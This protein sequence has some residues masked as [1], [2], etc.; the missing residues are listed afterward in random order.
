MFLPKRFQNVAFSISTKIVFIQPFKGVHNY[1]NMYTKND[2]FRVQSV[3]LA[4]PLALPVIA[5]MLIAQL[6]IKTIFR[7]PKGI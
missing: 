5:L 3:E 6:Q 7:E 1:C 4:T 2:I